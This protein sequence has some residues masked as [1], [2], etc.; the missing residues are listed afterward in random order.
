M[1]IRANQ[2]SDVVAAALPLRGRVV[3][4]TTPAPDAPIAGELR[5]SP[6]GTE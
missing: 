1:R 4:E 6:N 5:G 3:A 2:M